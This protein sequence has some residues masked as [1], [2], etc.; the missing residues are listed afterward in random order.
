MLSQSEELHYTMEYLL[1]EQA[2]SRLEHAL[3]LNPNFNRAWDLLKKI[4]K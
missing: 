2:K 4:E 3:D 1:W